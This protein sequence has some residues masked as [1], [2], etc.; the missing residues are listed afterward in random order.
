MQY[1]KMKSLYS[2]TTFM[3][4]LLTLVVALAVIGLGGYLTFSSWY[5]GA[6]ESRGS[7]S[8]TQVFEISQGESV[9]TIVQNLESAGLITNAQAMQ[10]YLRFN[11]DLA[12]GFQ[13]GLFDLSADMTIPEIAEALQKARNA[14]EIKVTIPEGLRYERIADILAEGFAGSDEATFSRAEFISIASNPDSV[15]FSADVAAFL[16]EYKPDGEPLEGFLYPE[17]YFF[18]MDT[19]AQ[20]VIERMIGTLIDELPEDLD[21]LVAASDLTFYESLTLA[22]I[23]EREGIDNQDRLNVASVFLNRLDIGMALQSDATVNYATGKSERRPTFATWRQTVR[24]ILISMPVSRRHRSPIR[25]L[26][27]SLPSLTRSKQTICF[28]SMRR[29]GH[30][31]TE[32]TCRSTIPTCAGTLT[33]PVR[34]RR[35]I[36]NPAILC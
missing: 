6:L 8:D 11:P 21:G 33:R 24:T 3:K 26:S 16:S 28:S 20:G 7:N 25:A 10:L 29:T 12:T 17:T 14:D 23:V 32:R 5:N 18:A 30:R 2:I 4:I 9:E 31:T 13:V 34:L 19:D 35:S 22:S 36:R 1:S 15:E 27:Q